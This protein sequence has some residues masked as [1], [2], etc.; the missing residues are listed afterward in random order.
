MKDK[1]TSPVRQG[2]IKPARQGEIW[3]ADLNP[4]VGKEQR[5]YHPVVILSGNML[6][7]H[8]PLVFA[9]PLTT[10]IKRY[11]G[12]PIIMPEPGNGLAEPSELLVFHFRSM[13]RER[14]VKKIGTVRPSQVIEAIKT[15][16]DLI[17]F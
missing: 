8:L 4:V 17:R 10:R 1:D 16:N 11:K 12:N 6:N 9:T 14:L 3:L 5:G 7:R 15:L 2:D 13:S